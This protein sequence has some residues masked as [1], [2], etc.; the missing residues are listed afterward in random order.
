MAISDSTLTS[1]EFVLKLTTYDG[2][3]GSRPPFVDPAGDIEKFK[4][5]KQAPLPH[6]LD[7]EQCQFMVIREGNGSPIDVAFLCF[8]D[9]NL[10]ESFEWYSSYPI[11]ADGDYS[12]DELLGFGEGAAVDQDG[13]LCFPLKKGDRWA[14]WPDLALER[15]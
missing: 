10:P 2:Q 14:F 1:T 4:A 9:P 6:P 11:F 15:L 7:G 3:P 12:D 8:Y 5:M 13:Y